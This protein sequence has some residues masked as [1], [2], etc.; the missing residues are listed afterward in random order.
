MADEEFELSE[1]ERKELKDAF[2][3]YDADRDE[4]IGPLEL[5]EIMKSRGYNPNETELMQLIR[6]VDDDN[7]GKIIFSELVEIAK[8]KMQDFDLE[9][10]IIEAF[11]VFDPDEIGFVKGKVL[12]KALAKEGIMPNEIKDILDEMGLNAGKGVID[13]NKLFK[14]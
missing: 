11:K 4:K 6:D 1:F 5:K 12:E 3:Y 2:D 10:E 13:Y 8:K 14:R 7:D 9:S